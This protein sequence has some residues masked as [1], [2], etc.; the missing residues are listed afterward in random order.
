MPVLN[1]RDIRLVGFHTLGQFLLGE[2]E[3]FTLLADILAELSCQFIGGHLRRHASMLYDLYGLSIRAARQRLVTATPANRCADGQ[4]FPKEF[5][6][7]DR[8]V[9]LDPIQRLSLDF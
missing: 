4:L 1:R 7:F 8:N 2:A 9:K 6:M 3:L 5:A